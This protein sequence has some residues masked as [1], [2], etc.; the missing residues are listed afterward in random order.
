[1]TAVAHARPEVC[2]YQWEGIED[3]GDSEVISPPSEEL[4]GIVEKDQGL[5]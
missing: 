4:L 3:T 2:V 1:M 5:Y